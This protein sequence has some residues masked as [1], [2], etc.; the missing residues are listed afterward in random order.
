MHCL[1]TRSRDMYMERPKLS[2]QLATQC[3]HCLQTLRARIVQGVAT[4]NSYID[5]SAKFVTCRLTRIS[6]SSV[7]S[8]KHQHSSSGSS[9]TDSTASSSSG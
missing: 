1:N 8:G 6:A 3:W 7:I 2:L 5:G 4:A 9:V